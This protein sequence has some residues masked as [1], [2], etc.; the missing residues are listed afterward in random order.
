MK[1]VPPRNNNVNTSYVLI[2]PPPLAKG[3]SPLLEHS[4]SNNTLTYV[5]IKINAI[6]QL[7]M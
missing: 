6:F 5:T 1:N 7:L 3:D 2:T 4:H